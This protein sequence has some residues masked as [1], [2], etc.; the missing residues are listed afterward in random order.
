MG[1]GVVDGPSPLAVLAGV[2]APGST[3]FVLPVVPDAGLMTVPVLLLV[4]VLAVPAAVMMTFD[5]RRTLAQLH[6][7]HMQTSFKSCIQMMSPTVNA[8]I[9]T[10]CSHS[11]A[12][13]QVE[14]A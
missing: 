12:R 4:L 5:E 1:L 9:T 7:Q 10:K 2:S 3:A 8:I 6:L 14:D 13:M 11:T